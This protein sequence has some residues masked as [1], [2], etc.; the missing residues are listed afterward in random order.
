MKRLQ[1]IFDNYHDDFIHNYFQ[2]KHLIL[3]RA[4]SNYFYK[5]L[6]KEIIE[7]YLQNV[8][9][10]YPDVRIVKNAEA[11]DTKLYVYSNSVINKKALFENFINGATIAFSGLH[12]SIRPLSVLTSEL[13]GETGHRFQTNVYLT[14]PNSQGFKIHYDSHDVIVLQVGGQK[15]WKIF[16]ESPIKWPHHDQKF[17]SGEYE[18]GNC[19]EDFTLHQGDTLYIPRGVWHSAESDGEYSL[20]ITIGY[21][22]TTWGDFIATYVQEQILSNVELREYVPFFNSNEKELNDIFLNKFQNIFNEKNT[23]EYIYNYVKSFIQKNQKPVISNYIDHARQ[24]GTID[25]KTKVER[26]SKLAF[27]ITVDKEELTIICGGEYII[28][29]KYTEGIVRELFNQDEPVCINDLPR[30]IDDEG[31]INLIKHLISKGVFMITFQ[32]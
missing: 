22:G 23:L 24:I 13:E 25:L 5:L 12:K 21:M 18:H 32:E 14:P 20:H 6:N 2:K 27:S 17:V 4:N 1:Y 3:K 15:K 26:T 8:E 28:L 7:N 30:S 11:I 31:K 29:P 9:L 10:R 16:D 19:I